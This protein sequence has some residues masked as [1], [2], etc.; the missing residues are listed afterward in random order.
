MSLTPGAIFGN[1]Q[2]NSRL[3]S[4]GMGEVYLALDQRLGRFVAL[5]LVLPEFTNSAEHLRRFEQ[6]ARAASALNHPNILTIHEIGRVEATSFIAAEFVEGETLRNRMRRK[7]ALTLAEVIDITVQVSEG[8]GAAHK[9]GILHRD[10]K[11]ENVMIRPDGY[12]KL[13][14]FGLA[15]LNVQQPVQIE[16]GD[17]ST[18]SV[19]YSNPGTVLGTLKYMSP[20]QL[21]GEPLD[22]R[23]DVW[24][25]GCV[26]YEMLAGHPPFEGPSS[27]ELIV[28][29]LE[30]QPEL[31]HIG[32][33]EFRKEVQL[34]LKRALAKAK[35]ERFATANELAAHLRE[36][37]TLIGS[38]GHSIKLTPSENSRERLFASQGTSN[39]PNPAVTADQNERTKAHKFSRALTL[40][41]IA[42]TLAFSVGLY[43]VY[44]AVTQRRSVSP[45]RAKAAI[46][47][48]DTGNTIDAVISPDGK[49][50]AYVVEEAEGQSLWGRQ[51]GAV[52]N[53]WPVIPRS[54]RRFWG[55]TFSP[56]GNYI[57][58]VVFDDSINQYVLYRTPALGGVTEKILEDVDTPI[59]FSPDGTEFTFVRGY[60]SD[61]QTALMVSTADGKQTRILAA[62]KSPDDF[63]WKGGPSWSPDG[64]LIACA[65]GRYETKM[66]VAAVLVRDGTEVRI[67][68]GEWPWIGRVVWLG[69]DQGLLMVAKDSVP[70]PPQIWHIGYPGGEAERITSDV[71][72]YSVKGISVTSDSTNIVAV[73]A[74]YLASIW[75][76]QKDRPGGPRRISVAKSDG[77]NGLAWLADGN[78]VM[79]SGAS[80]SLDIWTMSQDGSNRKQLTSGGSANYQPTA[81]RD[82]RYIIF[83]S[84]RGG[85]ED[86]WRMNTNGSDLLRLTNTGNADR[87]ECSPDGRWV[88]F[89]SYSSGSKTIWKVAIDGGEPV[90]LTSRYSDWPAVS[91]NGKH[92]VCEYWDEQPTTQAT[93]AVVPA[94]GGLPIS[95]FR[96]LP[97]TATALD[98]SNNVISWTPDGDAIVYIDGRSGVTNLVSQSLDGSAPKQITT[99]KEDRTFW[100]DWSM[101]GQALAFSRG[102]VTSDV[103]LFRIGK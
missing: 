45:V 29:V 83:V 63:G 53:S 80:G 3:G 100:F 96:F 81:T 70:L 13:V 16:L 89:K 28:S 24:S 15:K 25:I 60:P 66:Y 6:E 14:D 86:I 11:P 20:E 67:S 82:G 12:V 62:R 32:P 71:S 5:K 92:F 10:I 79:A 95:T 2:I 94:D 21:R 93:L 7:V 103:V 59:S 73:Q 101:D 61:K 85:G 17:E 26:L 98:L 42:G 23:S 19:V 8:I 72:H 51:V 97:A 84:T 68:K 56:D 52:S 90:R 41:L 22:P 44:S 57:Y 47:L 36:L 74:N 39:V 18:V 87:P 38:K 77:Y 9:A 34:I 58:F 43:L 50:L 27:A 54:P 4:G 30:K 75:V 55:L 76:S 78:L 69:S 88:F 46:K 102:V 91:P 35:S 1:Y 33:P 37:K 48:V 31:Q 64:T 40:L 49:Y 99:F 65:V